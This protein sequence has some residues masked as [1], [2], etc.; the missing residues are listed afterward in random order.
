MMTSRIPTLSTVSTICTGTLL[1]ALVAGALIASLGLRAWLH[2]SRAAEPPVTATAAV[3]P[4]PSL[5]PQPAAAL[6]AAVDAAP[7]PH[8]AD[9]ELNLMSARHPEP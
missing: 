5:P 3:A 6:S 7:A 1:S 4:L 2:T 9:W 8:Y